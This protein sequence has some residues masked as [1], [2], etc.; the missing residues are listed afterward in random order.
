MSEENY[1]T[2]TTSAVISVQNF[3]EGYVTWLKC[4]DNALDCFVCKANLNITRWFEVAC[5]NYD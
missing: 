5:D 4:Y 2:L 3:R 1:Y